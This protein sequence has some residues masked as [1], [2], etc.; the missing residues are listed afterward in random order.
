[1]HL[2]AVYDSMVV[3]IAVQLFIFLKEA[4]M[5]HFCKILALLAA[6]GG[7]LALTAV[8][9]CRRKRRKRTCYVTLYHYDD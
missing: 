6:A 7:L 3:I 1:M 9:C 4:G 5:K 2:G 8:L